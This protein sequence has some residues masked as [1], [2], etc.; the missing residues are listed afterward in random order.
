MNYR[1]LIYTLDRVT[2]WYKLTSAPPTASTLPNELK[3]EERQS[4]GIKAPMIIHGRERLPKE[5]D[6]KRGWR[7]FT[8]LRETDRT[9]V[10]TGH[11]R[12]PGRYRCSFTPN[13]S[14]F[15]F[16]PDSE[17]LTLWFFP[18]MSRRYGGIDDLIHLL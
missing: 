14:L 17:I 10:Y 15:R 8:G 5:L 6:P 3:V 2:G 16:S 4:G 7:W 13:F 11:F 18:G 12:T 9:N 1:K